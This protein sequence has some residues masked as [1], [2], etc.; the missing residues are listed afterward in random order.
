MKRSSHKY[1]IGI[2]AETNIVAPGTCWC[3]F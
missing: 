1:F 3:N 2:L